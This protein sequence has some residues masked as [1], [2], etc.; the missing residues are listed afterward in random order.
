MTLTRDC[1]SL[2]Q[3][4]GFRDIRAP[5]KRWRP[6]EPILHQPHHLESGLWI[7]AIFMPC[8]NAFR[9]C[10]SHLGNMFHEYWLLMAVSNMC[11]R[12]L[13][14]FCRVSYPLTFMAAR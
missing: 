1:Y 3:R 5:R 8:V 7:R 9:A 2:Q 6:S 11:W 10:L 4:S 12:C 13:N 14:G